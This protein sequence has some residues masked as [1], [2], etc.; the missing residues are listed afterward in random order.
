MSGL[1]LSGLASGLDWKSLVDQ[2][3]NLERTPINRLTAEQARNTSAAAALA[4]LGTRLTALQAAA[5]ALRDPGAFAG[6][7]V[8]LSGTGWSATVEA[9]AAAGSHELTI[10]ELATPTRRV[11]A[12]DA[13]AGLAATAD[14]SGL[15]LATLPTALP[16]TAGTFTINGRAVAVDLSDSLADVFAAIATAT[17][18]E[19][20]ATYDP[21]E[22]RVTLAG[23]GE[24]ALGAANDTSNLLRVLKLTQNGTA[25]VASSGALGTL[26]LAGPL[27][28]AGLRAAVTAVD[29]SGAGA[30]T[31]NGVTIAYNLNTDSLG[32]VLKRINQSGAGV[33]ASLDPASDRVVLTNTSGGDL[34]LAV[35]EEPGGLLAALGLTG[36]G[37]LVRGRNTVFTVDGGALQEH[38]GATLDAAALGLA[39]VTLRPNAAGTQVVTVAPDTA[40]MRKRIEAFI[41][42]YNSV[43]T[44]IDERTRITTS[45]DKVTTAVLSG[46]REVQAWASELRVLAFGAGGGG[47]RLEGLGID[48]ASGSNQ[49][50]LKDPARLDAALRDRPAA[51][52]GFFQATGTGF[53]AR[54]ATRLTALGSANETQQQRLTRANAGLDRQIADLE[55]RLEQQRALME[56]AFIRMEEAQ[57]RLNSQSAALARFLGTETED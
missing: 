6:S 28:E 53:A 43:Q 47:L 52:E 42:A 13:G 9:T 18:G 27:A 46:N 38:P 7:T 41:T 10:H 8:A 33:T 32:A 17:D 36:V 2:L 23:A 26:R 39:G 19:V 45:A 55:R 49:L 21:V 57:S 25:A 37:A 20:V 11:G 4:E 3:M 16:V 56:A 51:V 22:D 30:F 24:I 54:L 29:A 50:A 34:G 5:T 15:T 14:V 35:T 12:A 48:F 31:I 1:Q 40:G 44:F